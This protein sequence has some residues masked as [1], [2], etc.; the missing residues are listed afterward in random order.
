[1]V[2]IFT[3]E[4]LT[5]LSFTESTELIFKFQLS[6]STTDHEEETVQAQRKASRTTDG[7]HGKRNKNNIDNADGTDLPTDKDDSEHDVNVLCCI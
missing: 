7:N 5:N 4:R 6:E 3:R 1:M 2:V